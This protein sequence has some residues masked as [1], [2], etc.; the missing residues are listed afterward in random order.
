MFLTGL[1]ASLSPT[2]QPDT[3]LKAFIHLQ[4]VF[5]YSH[6]CT[7]VFVYFHGLACITHTRPGTFL[8]VEPEKFQ[9]FRLN[10]KPTWLSCLYLHAGRWLLNWPF[11]AFLS[12]C[13][14][15]PACCICACHPNQPK[16]GTNI[17]L[18]TAPRR[19]SSNKQHNTGAPSLLW[20]G[21]PD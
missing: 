10:K 15:Y 11:L 13:Q 1:H 6:L 4:C 18:P 8:F 7:F 14:I 3:V 5:V 12:S 21:E 17:V 2:R 19:A 9:Q 20:V 16:F